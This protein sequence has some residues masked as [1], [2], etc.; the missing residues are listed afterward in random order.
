[1]VEN[2]LIEEQWNVDGIK[3]PLGFSFGVAQFPTEAKSLGEMI[4][5]ADAK[6]YEQKKLK[7][8]KMSL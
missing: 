8:E 4:K 3:I 2:K 5:C 7:K 1:M 6:L